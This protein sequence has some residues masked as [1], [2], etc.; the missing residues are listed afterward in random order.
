MPFLCF[1]GR[2]APSPV[3]VTHG[4]HGG[5]QAYCEGCAV[6]LERGDTGPWRPAAPLSQ[7]A[8]RLR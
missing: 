8:S 7:A 6:P 1:F 5:Y 4:K 3:S 2:H